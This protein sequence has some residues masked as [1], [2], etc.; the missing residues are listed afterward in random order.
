MLLDLRTWMIREHVGMMKLTGAYD[1]L[2]PS[3]GEV[4]G[5]AKE[6]PGALNK[7]L[8]IFLGRDRLSTRVDIHNGADEKE[9][10]IL[11]SIT[12]SFSFFRPKVQV[13][14]AEG[15]KIGSFKKKMISMGGTL[16]VFDEKDEEFAVLKGDWKGK[17][18]KLLVGDNEVGV[19][20]QQWAGMGKELFTSA[21]NYIVN[22][23]GELSNE[24]AMLM[25]G[26][27]LAID[28]IY[29]ED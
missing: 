9:S 23:E 15:T 26:A 17:N 29:K 7:I 1:I 20:S 12:K 25:L 6:R 28:L 5:I 2:D 14:D 10:P 21:D 8:G 18:F 4:I 16:R 11:F 3:S 22:L 27:G 24:Y 19:I 13:V